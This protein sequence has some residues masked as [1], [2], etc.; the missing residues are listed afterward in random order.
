MDPQW[1]S[2]LV[3]LGAC[4]ILAGVVIADGGRWMVAGVLVIA[5]TAVVAGVRA[6]RTRGNAGGHNGGSA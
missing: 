6:A 5:A 3:Y 4:A 1:R 2:Y